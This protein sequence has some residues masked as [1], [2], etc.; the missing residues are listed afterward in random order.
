MKRYTFHNAGTR[1]A[2][3]PN[4]QVA[5]GGTMLDI[6]VEL[7]NAANRRDVYIIDHKGRDVNCA[8]LEVA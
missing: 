5:G 1:T 6:H 2:F 3:N 7:V 4:Q 8:A